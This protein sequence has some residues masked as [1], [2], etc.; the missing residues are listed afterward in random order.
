MPRSDS[1]R[2]PVVPLYTHLSAKNYEHLSEIIS[3]YGYKSIRDAVN[4]LIDSAYRATQKDVRKTSSSEGD[5]Q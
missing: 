1:C 4:C 5:E 2:E 3:F